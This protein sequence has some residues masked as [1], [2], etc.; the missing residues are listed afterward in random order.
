[1]RG[2][3]QR[4]E[5][6]VAQEQMEQV[7]EV[8]DAVVHRR[9][10][11]EQ[12]GSTDDQSGEGPVAVGI[13]IPETVGL[14]DDEQAGGWRMVEGGGGRSA[15]RLVCQDRTVGIVSREQLAT[16]RGQDGRHDD[17][18]PPLQ[19]ERYREGDV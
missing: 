10:R 3:S 9:R 2:H 19:R 8:G 13:G 4:S 14:V 1:Q 6:V 18:G 7:E 11:D 15:E 5:I 16:V 12:Y 17:G